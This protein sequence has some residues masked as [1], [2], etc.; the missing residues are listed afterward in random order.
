MTIE[1]SKRRFIEPAVQTG[2][3]AKRLRPILD[4]VLVRLIP[5]PS[6]SEGGIII[7][8]KAKERPKRGTI[9]AVG[10][11]K[12]TDNGVFIEPSV[13]VG[14]VAVF[15]QYAGADAIIGGEKMRLLRESEILAVDE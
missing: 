3:D 4:R 1:A 5:D 7:P 15:T 2:S 14:E 6:T 10:P 12:M 13:A 11:G 8:D 9:V